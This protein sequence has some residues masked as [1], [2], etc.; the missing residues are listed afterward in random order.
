M[1]RF[2]HISSAVAG[3]VAVAC[4]AF[5]GAV[6]GGRIGGWADAGGGSRSGGGGPRDIARVRAGQAHA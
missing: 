6:P 5:A 2:L 4:I 3:S 1:T